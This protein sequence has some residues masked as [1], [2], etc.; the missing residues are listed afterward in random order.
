M[1][2]AAMEMS[3]KFWGALQ[4]RAKEGFGQARKRLEE[5]SGKEVRGFRMPEGEINKA[6]LEVLKEFG[7]LLQQLPFR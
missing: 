2:S 3:M 1:K 7:F 4:R 6:T 5:V